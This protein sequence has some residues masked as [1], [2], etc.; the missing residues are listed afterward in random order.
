ME[1][2]TVL[3][4]GSTAGIGRQT[5][6]DLARAGA[7]VL[8]HARDAARGEPVLAALAQASGSQNL[9]LVLGD[10]SSLAGVAALAEGVRERTRRLDAL[11]NNAAVFRKQRSLTE[12][13]FETTFAV[14]HLAPFRL[15]GLLLELLAAAPRAR[16]IN[17]ASMAH[18][19]GRLDFDN[20]QGERF[21]DGFS[22]YALSKLANVMFT[23]ELADRLKATPITVNCL[24]PG[25]VTTR[26]LTE[27]F[28]ITGIPVER[29]TRCLLHLALSP[30]VEGVSGKYFVDC[31]PAAPASIALESGVRGKL[32]ECAESLVGPFSGGRTAAQRVP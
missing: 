23:L 14:N 19:G 5:A 6:L 24:H 4:T 13:G 1:N 21:Y 15:T 22:A 30:L 16:I 32:W 31:R 20:L 3:V 2:V 18:S 25:V 29:C 12:D 17:V 26:L 7:R 11:I 28:G 27:G 8:L 10:L 9:E